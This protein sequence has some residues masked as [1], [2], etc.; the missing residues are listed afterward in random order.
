MDFFKTSFFFNVH[1]IDSISFFLYTIFYILFI[2]YFIYFI[3][4]DNRKEITNTVL[5]VLYHNNAFKDR[6]AIKNA[7]S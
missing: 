3:Y 7:L 6:R 2:Y 4:R 1:L 5:F